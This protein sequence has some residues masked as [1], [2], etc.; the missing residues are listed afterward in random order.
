MVILAKSGQSL[1]KIS[2]PWG[3]TFLP[4]QICFFKA[5]LNL[6]KSLGARFLIFASNFFFINPKLRHGII[7]YL[8][9]L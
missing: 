2:Q 6:Q 4:E 1:E 8:F 3:F 5:R 7:V 9:I